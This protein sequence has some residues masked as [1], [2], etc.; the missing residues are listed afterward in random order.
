MR[1]YSIR[2]S[3]DSLERLRTLET[4]EYFSPSPPFISE[5][6]LYVSSINPTGL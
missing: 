1:T 3:E 5:V 4:I 2:L 6:G